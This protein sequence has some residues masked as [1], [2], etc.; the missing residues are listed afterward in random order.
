MTERRQ[1]RMKHLFREF[2]ATL[3]GSGYGVIDLQGRGYYII[4][5]LKQTDYKPTI[6]RKA[7]KKCT[8]GYSKMQQKAA[9]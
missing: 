1:R 5:Y 9:L 4:Q 6:K 2:W 3:T 7:G 8:F